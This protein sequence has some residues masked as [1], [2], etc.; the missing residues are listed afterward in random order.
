[1]H[2]WAEFGLTM[3]RSLIVLYSLL[4]VLGFVFLPLGGIVLALHGILAGSDWSFIGGI[5][6]IILSMLIWFH[7]GPNGK[8]KDL[9]R[10]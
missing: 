10:G 1:M 9:G 6:A 5:T 4:W 7:F 8:N 3:N 2:N